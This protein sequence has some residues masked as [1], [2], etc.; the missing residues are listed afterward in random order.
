MVATSARI[1]P[2]NRTPRACWWYFAF[3]IASVTWSSAEAQQPDTVRR[4]STGRRTPRDSA[5]AVADS[6]AIVRELERAQN[7][8]PGQSAG[9]QGQPT[10][11]RLLPDISVVGDLIGDFSPDGSTQEGGERFAVRELELAL[12]A[13]VDPYFRGDVFL[14]FSDAEGVHIEQAYMTATSLPWGL[15]LRL[16]RF[17]MPVGK[18]S[19]T[20]RHDLHTVEYPHV[21]Q[22]FFGPE[23]LKGTGLYASRVF[24]PFGFYQEL[25][26]TGVDRFGE[27]P[28]DGG[29]TLEPINKKLSG[30]GYSARLRNY[31][32]LNQAS[33]LELSFSG[34]TGKREQPVERLEDELF[35]TPARQ[36]VIGVDLTYR[37]RPLQQGLYRS[38]ILQAE[39]MRQLN[40]RDP[41]LLLPDGVDPDDFTYAGPDRDFSGAYVFARYQLTRRGHVGARFDTFQDEGAAGRTST[42]VSGYLQWFPSEFSKLTA[43]YERY[44]PA[45]GSATNRL[46]LQA[47]F[48]LGPHK[49]HPF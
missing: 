37:W 38:F 10:N 32:D 35:A 2:S 40:E 5:R 21:I 22:R 14:G 45:E 24:A 46:L 20:H 13:A 31:W 48:A 44:A 49:P 36:S 9:Q 11:P 30:L 26:V 29:P 23:G 28:E 3:A 6:I 15:E 41:R 4:D 33:N 27:A 7:E 17:L 19:T 42:A 12:Q 16:G 1:A 8:R 47:T 18:Q 25:I 39:F 34:I 43:A